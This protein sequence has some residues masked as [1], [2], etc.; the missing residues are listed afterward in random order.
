MQCTNFDRDLVFLNIVTESLHWVLPEDASFLDVIFVAH[1]SAADK[2]YYEYLRTSETTWVLP[3]SVEG[4]EISPSLNEVIVALGAMVR[5]DIE[6]ISG[7]RFDDDAVNE[8]R[9]LFLDYLDHK[10]DPRYSHRISMSKLSQLGI[11]AYN[12][13]HSNTILQ[14]TS[15]PATSSSSAAS[16][17]AASNA[18]IQIKQKEAQEDLDLIPD[19]IVVK[20]GQGVLEVAVV[21]VSL[22]VSFRL[23]SFLLLI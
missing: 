15:M 12:L 20:N 23:S 17:T 1:Q 9:D 7:E 18:D 16:A 19:S 8:Q 3:T 21:K 10:D 6:D 22:C 11:S 14:S 2:Y 13:V 5:E 4:Y